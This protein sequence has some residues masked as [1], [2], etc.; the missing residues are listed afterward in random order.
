V[1]ISYGSVKLETLCRNFRT[2]T[3]ELGPDGAKKLSA[4]WADLEAAR[5]VSELIAGRPHPLERDR[6]GQFALSLAGGQRLV[7]RPDH[8]PIPARPGGGIAWENVTRVTIV[9]VGNYHD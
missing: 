5:T 7:F 4:R 6:Y 3:R 1:N 8:D 2:A 9:F